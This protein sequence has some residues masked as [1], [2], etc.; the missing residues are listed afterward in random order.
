MKYKIPTLSFLITLV[1][2]SCSQPRVD[3]LPDENTIRK[4]QQGILI[5]GDNGKTLQWLGIPYGEIVP[6]EDRWK[7]SKEPRTWDGVKEALKFGSFCVQQGSLVGTAQR[8][9]WGNIIGSENCLNL[10]IWAPKLSSKEIESETANYPVMLWI[11]GGSNVAGNS[12][13]YNPTELVYQHKVIV[14]TINYRL[15]PFGWFRHPSILSE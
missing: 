9:D 4:T 3:L 11:H 1:L 14:V 7:Q 13:F 15:G 6:S 10:N 2:M 5:G 8:K 12:N